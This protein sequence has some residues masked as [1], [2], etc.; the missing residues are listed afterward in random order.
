MVSHYIVTGM[1]HPKPGMETELL[2]VWENTLVKHA[3]RCGSIN[4]AIYLN[5]ETGEFLSISHWKDMEGLEKFFES[6][7]ME[8][9]S[10]QINQICL[11]PATR[12]TYTILKEE[13]SQRK[14]A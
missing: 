12:E 14:V 6:K 4:L 1:Y 5:E 10:N 13:K 9:I 7:E 8:E 3:T 11:I 2:H